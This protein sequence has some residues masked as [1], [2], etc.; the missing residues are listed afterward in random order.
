MQ[1]IRDEINNS[2][3]CKLGYW[4]VLDPLGKLVDSHQHMGETA[5]RRCEGPDHIKAPTSKGPGWWYGDEAVGW[6]MRLLAEE[7]TILAQGSSELDTAVGHQKL[8]LYALPTSV[9]EAAWLP[10]NL[11]GSLAVCRSHLPL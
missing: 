8:A 6:N 5:W 9:L 11:R 3:W 4:L 10:Q 7:L 1:D 2:V